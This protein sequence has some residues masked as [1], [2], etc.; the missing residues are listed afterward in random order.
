MS[1]IFIQRYEIEMTIFNS[2]YFKKINFKTIYLLF[3]SFVQLSNVLHY[4]HV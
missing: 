1:C 2:N 3:Y 4:V